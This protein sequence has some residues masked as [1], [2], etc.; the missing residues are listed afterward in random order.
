MMAYSRCSC[1]L[2]DVKEK[3]MIKLNIGDKAPDFE[4]PITM[5]QMW[6]LSDHIGKQNIVI[7]FFPFAYSP[8]CHA[9]MCSFRDGFREFKALDA[10]VVG[11]SVDNPFVLVK[12]KEDL[13]LPFTLLS[14]FN[15]T[16]GPAYGAHHEKLGPLKGVE[17]RSAFVIDK[18]GII[19]YASVSEDPLV[20]PDVAAI[21]KVLDGLK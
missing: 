21:K 7:L 17:K 15:K 13:G 11:I 10:L 5:D 20:L 1:F 12:W 19:R 18:K 4:L 8:P 9:E 3:T 16:V 14:D 6:K 2:H